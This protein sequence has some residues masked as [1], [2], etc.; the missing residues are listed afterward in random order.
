MGREIIARLALLDSELLSLLFVS[1]SAAV[2]L[3]MG[4]DAACRAASG[5]YGGG[6]K[7]DSALNTSRKDSLLR[8]HDGGRD[9]RVGATIT[10][11][12]RTDLRLQKNGALLGGSGSLSSR[13]DGEWPILKKLRLRSGV[14][15][16]EIGGRSM[17]P[18]GAAIMPKNAALL[19]LS[20]S[21]GFARLGRRRIE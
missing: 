8:R 2:A 7:P 1:A 20:I 15:L 13:G 11:I 19:C 9:L 4:E 3:T 16:A 17:Q 6:I 14:T 18:T 21:K 12:K 10:L 5:R